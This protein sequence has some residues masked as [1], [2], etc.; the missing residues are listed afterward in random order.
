MDV[1]QS[2]KDSENALRD[3]IAAVLSAKHGDGWLEHVGLSADRLAIWKQRKETEAKRQEAGVVEERILYYADF[4]DLSTILKK[5]WQDFAP[6]LGD[7]KSMEVWLKEL[8]RLRDPDAH[9]REL[10]PHQKHLVLGISGEIR[11]RIVRY[12]SKQET[13]EDYFPRI[14]S[15]RDSLGN[16]WTPP[17]AMHM[18]STQTVLRPG[19]IVD[20]VVTATDPLA[21]QLTYGTQI[22]ARSAEIVWQDGGTFTVRIKESDVRRQF[23]IEVFI[24]SS[25]DHHA[26]SGHDDSVLITYQVLPRKHS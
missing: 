16:I 6:A 12:R 9:R 11:N 24:K 19:D 20:I 3:F 8:E 1:T 17:E 10:L 22:V 2:L 23:F 25:R 4:Y 7:W 15:I 13:A 21:E 5:N 18:M 14:E 26:S